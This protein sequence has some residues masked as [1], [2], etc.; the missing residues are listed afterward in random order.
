MEIDDELLRDAGIADESR[1][2]EHHGKRLDSPV[3]F[4]VYNVVDLL[5]L[6]I[7]PR[8]FILEPI[9]RERDLVELYSWRGCGK[10]M[11]SLA[12]AYAIATAGPCLRW[13]AP[14]ARRVLYVDGE[15]PL[16]TLQ[17]RLAWFVASQEAEPPSPDYLRFLTHDAQEAGLPDLG[18]REGQEAVEALLDDIDFLV[19]DSVSTLIKSGK[20]NTAEDWQCFQDWLLQLRSRGKTVMFDHHEGKG[21]QQRGTSKRE[22]VL[23]TC[24]QLTRPSDYSPDQ[25]AR[26]EVHF[27]KC[28]AL[29]GE[30]AKSFEAQLVTTDGRAEW[31]LRDSVDANFERAK[32]LFAMNMSVRDVADE[33]KISK[34]VAGRLRMRWK[35]SQGTA[36]KW[37]NRPT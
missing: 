10:T 5:T 22:D 2:P 16:Q 25:G 27:K 17:E 18:L 11:V 14:K 19:F 12:V 28:R 37:D 33:L 30:P 26:F 8:E 6:K 20:E 29:Q 3:G 9:I 32:E 1:S 4:R 34:T 15:L 13:H 31:F 21:G 35:A 36:E 23:D 24:I 7:P